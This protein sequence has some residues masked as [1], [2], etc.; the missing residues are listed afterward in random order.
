MIAFNSDWFLIRMRVVAVV[1]LIDLAI[2]FKIE[3]VISEHFPVVMNPRFFQRY[4]S[5]Q[6]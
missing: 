3:L 6:K 1:R 4:W 5:V 2:T